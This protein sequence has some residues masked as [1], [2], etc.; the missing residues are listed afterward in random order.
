VIITFADE[1]SEMSALANISPFYPGASVML[2]NSFPYSFSAASA[3][4][5]LSN[6][7]TIRKDVVFNIPDMLRCIHQIAPQG[8]KPPV[9]IVI[10]ISRARLLIILESHQEIV[11]YT[12]RSSF[13]HRC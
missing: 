8:D 13:L 9:V 4:S 3:D 5:D 7:S 1:N 12:I 11:Y 6:H 2:T 10:V